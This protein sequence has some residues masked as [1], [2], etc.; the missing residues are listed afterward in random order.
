MVTS[1]LILPCHSQSARLFPRLY[2]EAL[3]GKAEILFLAQRPVFGDYPDLQSGFPDG[4]E[5]ILLEKGPCHAPGKEL[6]VIPF[7]RRQVTEQ[8]DVRDIHATAILQH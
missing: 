8:H 6:L 5:V 4:P 7:L 2:P 3:Y 1:N